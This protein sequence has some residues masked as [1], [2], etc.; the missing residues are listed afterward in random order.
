[1]HS[2][3]LKKVYMGPST[4]YLPVEMITMTLIL[5]LGFFTFQLATC[6]V[7]YILKA[8]RYFYTVFY[9]FRLRE[10]AP[11]ARTDP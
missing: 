5:I 6:D 8:C 4:P 1:M 3:H 11:A 7:S 2:K 10:S 9:L